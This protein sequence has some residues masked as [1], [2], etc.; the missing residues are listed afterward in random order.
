MYG[1]GGSFSVGSHVQRDGAKVRWEYCTVRFHASW[2]MVPWEPGP[3]EQNGRQTRLK[4]LP[5][6]NFVGG[7]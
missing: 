3:R 4:T 5:S 7:W 6:H 1:R 2:A